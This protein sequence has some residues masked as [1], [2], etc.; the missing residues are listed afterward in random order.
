MAN[1]AENIEAYDIPNAD[2]DV[3]FRHVPSSELGELDGA[4]RVGGPSMNATAVD[5]NALTFCDTA[6]TPMDG[7]TGR[8]QSHFPTKNSTKTS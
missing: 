2:W 8:D 7:F 6:R 3:P 1:K 4:G 5:L